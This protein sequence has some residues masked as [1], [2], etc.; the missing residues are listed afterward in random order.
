MKAAVAY[1]QNSTDFLDQVME[2]LEVYT[3]V[4]KTSFVHGKQHIYMYYM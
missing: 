3:G 4:Y 1:K 2:E